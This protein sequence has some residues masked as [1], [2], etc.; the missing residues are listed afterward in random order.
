MDYINLKFKI[1]LTKNKIN[2]KQDQFVSENDI[3]EIYNKLKN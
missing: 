3:L 2:I 1:A